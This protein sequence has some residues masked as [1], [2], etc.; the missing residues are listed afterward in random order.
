MAPNNR[1]MCYGRERRPMSVASLLPIFDGH[2]DV[3]LA[4]YE[5][6][7]GEGVTFFDHSE[8][9]H[10][11]LPR[12]RAGGFAGGFFAV[13]VPADPSVSKPEP[14]DLPSTGLFEMPLPPPL[15]LAYAQRVAFAM[16]ALLFRAEAASD[17]QIKVVR[18]TDQ[19]AACLRD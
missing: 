2:N 8:K 9:G 11:D 4:L 12:A 3:L 7:R 13:Y 5:R 17:G 10:L 18:T 6:D 15:G 19:L 16:A 14:T 1:Q